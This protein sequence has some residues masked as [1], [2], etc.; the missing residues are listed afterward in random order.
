MTLCETPPSPRLSTR[1][2]VLSRAE[3]QTALEGGALVLAMFIASVWQS[4]ALQHY[5]A[6]CFASG[7]HA[8]ALVQHSLFRRLIELPQTTIQDVTAGVQECEGLGKEWKGGGDDRVG[9][10]PMCS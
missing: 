6:L 4:L 8:K 2:L 1:A 3:Y 7:A 5:I 9:G 10:A